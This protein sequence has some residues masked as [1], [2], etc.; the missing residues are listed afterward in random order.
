MFSAVT[1]FFSSSQS[2]SFKISY[3]TGS[4]TYPSVSMDPYGTSGTILIDAPNNSWTVVAPISSGSKNTVYVKVNSTGTIDWQKAVAANAYANI[5]IQGV[6]FVSSGNIYINSNV[7]F[8]TGTVVLDS[9]G[10]FIAEGGWTS[11]SP[12][13]LTIVDSARSQL[14]TTSASYSNSTNSCNNIYVSGL[15]NL[16]PTAGVVITDSLS[17]GITF[18]SNFV[19]SNRL[20][21]IGYAFIT[22]SGNYGVIGTSSV[23]PITSNTTFSGNFLRKTTGKVNTTI[24]DAVSNGTDLYVTGYCN[25]TSGS[26]NYS[27][28]FVAKFTGL[29]GA[30]TYSWSRFITSSTSSRVS[31]LS[32]YASANG[33]IYNISADGVTSNKFIITCYSPTG[34]L[35]F[36]RYL[37]IT[38]TSATMMPISIDS[39]TTHLKLGAT[40]SLSSV[41]YPIVFDIPLDGIMPEAGSYTVGSFAFTFTTGVETITSDTMTLSS[42]ILST[43]A[44]TISGTTSGYYPTATQITNFSP[45]TKIAI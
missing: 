17:N 7:N 38:T 13:G 39:N 34:T 20:I 44:M 32:C 24:T 5:D 40:V 15:S 29:G 45:T 6:S 31:F 16:V 4:G 9:S 43:T 36:T 28:S 8:G 3:L 10:N 35:I 27:D 22:G 26:P 12:R 14:I 41:N 21:L 18:R 23:L 19:S 25:Q 37:T 1:S 42:K 11:T 2:T 33:N 30:L